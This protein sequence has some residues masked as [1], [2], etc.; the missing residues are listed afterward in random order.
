MTEA[1]TH[2]WQEYAYKCLRESG[3]ESVFDFARRHETWSYAQ[4][5]D[6]LGGNKLAPIQIQ[7]LLREEVQDQLMH[8]YYVRS[9]LVRNL[10]E[11]VP[12]GI[13][14]HD[15]WNLILALSSWVGS[16]DERDRPR[17]MRIAQSVK[18][19]ADVSDDWLPNFVDDSVLEKLAAQSQ[20]IS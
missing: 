15:E 3:C 13:R 19:V 8:E 20:E 4:L 2:N 1:W 11:H 9:S 18:K 6:N 12:K 17:C 10:H 14:M 16:M 7:R 5:A